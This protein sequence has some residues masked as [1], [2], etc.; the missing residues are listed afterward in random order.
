MYHQHISAG[1]LPYS[2]YYLSLDYIDYFRK[3]V[4]FSPFVS[5]L[6]AM[7]SASIL[8]SNVLTSHTTIRPSRPA[9]ETFVT[10]SLLPAYTDNCTIALV[11]V[12]VDFTSF[13]PVARLSRLRNLSIALIVSFLC[14]F[15][16]LGNE[17]ECVVAIVSEHHGHEVVTTSYQRVLCHPHT[18]L[19]G[20]P[21]D[22]QAGYLCPFASLYN[23]NTGVVGHPGNLSTRW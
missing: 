2:L 8:L 15:I 4:P 16:Q 22:I 7:V 6:H 10:L 5:D 1:Y 3:V 14:R 17:G 19:E 23:R 12:V 13:E 20:Q 18:C 9:D 11:W 21:V